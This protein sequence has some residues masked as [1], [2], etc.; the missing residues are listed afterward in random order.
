MKNIKIFLIAFLFLITDVKQIFPQAGQL[1]TT[2]G[3]GGIVTNIINPLKKNS[4]L[5]AIAIRNDEKIIVAGS[6]NGD[7]LAMLYNQ[8]GKLD[9][10]FGLNGIASANGAYSEEARS[11]AIQNDGKLVA[12]GSSVNGGSQ[13]FALVRYNIDGS[14][15][16]TFGNNGIVVSPIGLSSYSSKVLIQPDQKIVVVGASKANNQAEYIFTIAR[17]N[18]DGTLDVTFGTNGV[19]TTTLGTLDSFPYSAQIQIDGKIVVAGR[20]VDG[21]NIITL[22]RYKADGSLDNT[23]GSSGIVT[24]PIENSNCE[25]RSV[26][27]QNDGKI[28]IAGDYANGSNNDDFVIVRYNSDGNL[29]NSFGTNGVTLTPIGAF[30]DEP[31]AVGIQEDGKIIA[32]GRTYNGSDGDFVLVRYNSNGSLDNA[33]GN[34]G[35]KVIV[36]E[37]SF[38]TAYDFAVLNNGK[39][40]ATGYTS[41]TNLDNSI[42]VRFNADGSLDNTFGNNGIEITEVGFPLE[43]IN[44]VALQNNNGEE[45]IVANSYSWNGNN[46]DFAL[47]RFNPDGTLDNTFGINGNVITTIGDSSNNQIESMAVQ[48]DGKIVAA[49]SSYFDS[50]HHTVAIRFTPNGNLDNSFGTGGISLLPANNSIQYVYSAAI[51]DDGKIIASGSSYLGNG[52]GFAAVRYNTDGSFD[53]TF[54]AEGVLFIPIGN[55]YSFAFS[56]AIQDDGK[57]ILAGSYRNVDKDNFALIRCNVDGRLDS[58]FGIGGIVNVPIGSSTNRCYSIQLQNDG[59]IIAAG[60][61]GDIHDSQIAVVRYNSDGSLDNSF[62][63]DGIVFTPTADSSSVAYSVKLQGDGKIVIGGSDNGESYITIRYNNDGSL[64]PTFGLNGIITYKFGVTY[65]IIRSIAIQNDGNI[66]AA[67]FSGNEDET[68]SLS[69]IIRYTGEKI[70]DVVIEDKN[71]EI[72]GSFNLFQ[73]YPNPFNPSTT[74]RFSLPKQT[75]LRINVYNILGELVKTIAEGVYEA[76]VYKVNFDAKNLT[77]GT[78]IYRIENGDFIQAKK[79]LLIK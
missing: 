11:L 16:Q 64:D 68:R 36:L 60:S 49:G 77:S 34:N 52:S 15:D 21:T 4:F 25:A 14:K 54:G 55:S 41:G 1:D 35:I 19:V 24:T 67:G 75:E 9:N 50:E 33:F 17:Y 6:S 32:A 65:N 5:R 20:S 45:K 62:G 48:N 37:N 44:S 63:T 58:T 22:V 56:S 38:E 18:P 59:K 71:T 26:T 8:D 57:I 13:N 28:I 29:D 31:N 70:N 78:Y 42:T 74:I 72:P 61:Y 43:N 23:F 73:N 66:I 47:S 46:N 76:G 40:I 79:M 7:F 27:I 39:I 69:T 30:N 2:F 51:Q 3:Q 10:S 53:N 12:A